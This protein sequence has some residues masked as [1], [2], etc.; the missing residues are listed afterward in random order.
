MEFLPLL[1]VEQRTYCD[2][3]AR[4]ATKAVLANLF[5]S[6]RTEELGRAVARAGEQH[7]VIVG[8]CEL[9]NFILVDLC[10]LQCRTGANIN[11]L[12][13]SSLCTDVECLVE[14]AP[15]CASELL[16]RDRGDFLEHFWSVF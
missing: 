5:E 8:H 16:A 13:L 1:R 2:C 10:V 14:W 12:N 11:D 9:V 15:G 6:L 3:A 7:S 4:S